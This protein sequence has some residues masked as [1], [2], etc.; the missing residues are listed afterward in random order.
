VGSREPDSDLRVGRP[1]EKILHTKRLREL[2]TSAAINLLSSSPLLS[3][4]SGNAYM[5]RLPLF[6]QRVPLYISLPVIVACG[7]AGYIANTIGP[8]S[9]IFGQAQ[10]HRPA[11]PEPSHGAVATSPATPDQKELSGSSARPR[12]VQSVALLPADEVALPT[13]APSVI[14]R[15]ERGPANVIERAP[16][17]AKA[18]PEHPRA[19]RAVRAVSKPRRPQRVVRQSTSTPATASTGLKSIPLI[20]PVFSLL[21]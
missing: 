21:Q 3:V 19:T 4:A 14:E 10:I 15:N 11:E 6:S 16:P 13:P 18:M 9:T 2:G 17:L 7:A 8:V 12:D 5:S 1:S 20:G